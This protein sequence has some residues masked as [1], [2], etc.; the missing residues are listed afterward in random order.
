MH[1]VWCCLTGCDRSTCIPAVDSECET[2]GWITREI[3]TQ[4]TEVRSWKLGLNILKKKIIDRLL[5]DRYMLP[6]EL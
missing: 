3:Y 1:F 2:L 5:W 4:R 6:L